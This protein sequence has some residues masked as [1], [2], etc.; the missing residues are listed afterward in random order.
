MSDKNSLINLWQ[1]YKQFIFFCIAG[2]YN[3]LFGLGCFAILYHNFA[4][5]LHYLVISVITNVTSIT[6]AYIV[7]RLFVFK[8]KGNIIREYL[9]FNVVYGVSF[10]VSLVM[11]FILVD[12]VDIHPV[13]SQGVILFSGVLI[14][15]FG[16]RNYSFQPAAPS[17]AKPGFKREQKEEDIHG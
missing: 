11:M 7:Y 12:F 1:R 3:T 6:N 10:V 15:F 9:R 14:S 16:H 13:I 8:S 2:G 17:S 4:N 5:D